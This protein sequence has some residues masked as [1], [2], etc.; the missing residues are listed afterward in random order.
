MTD[1]KRP[2][3]RSLRRRSTVILAQLCSRHRPRETYAK[4][5]RDDE[6]RVMDILLCGDCWRLDEDTLL[7]LCRSLEL[8]NTDIE[9]TRAHALKE[10]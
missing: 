10:R 2:L 3:P 8:S 6:E 7:Q 5:A 1:G 4:L 9:I